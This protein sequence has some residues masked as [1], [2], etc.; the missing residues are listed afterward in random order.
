MFRRAHGD[1]VEGSGIGLAVCRRI[2]EAHGGAIAAQRAGGGGT[3]RFSLPVT[4]ARV[5]VPAT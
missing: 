3:M 4:S 1:D 2:V 5:G